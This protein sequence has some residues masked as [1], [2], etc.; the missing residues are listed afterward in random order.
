MI[1]N[2]SITAAF[3]GGLISF[4]SPCVV[5]LVPAFLSN[6]AGVSL[7]DVEKNETVYRKTVLLNTIFFI[8]GFTAVFV[9]L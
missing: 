7:S 8:L 1:E 2:I 9:T 5:V 4:F 3:I 6:L